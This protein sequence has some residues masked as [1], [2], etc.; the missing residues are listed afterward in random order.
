MPK[1]SQADSVK[2]GVVILFGFKIP[3]YKKERGNG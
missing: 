3:R 1:S 2:I